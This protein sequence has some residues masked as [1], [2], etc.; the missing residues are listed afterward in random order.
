MLLLGKLRFSPSHL[1]L[2]IDR[3]TACVARDTGNILWKYTFQRLHCMQRGR[4]KT[5]NTTGE[6][7]Y[8]KWERLI[9][10][11]ICG[12]AFQGVKLERQF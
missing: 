5:E 10:L 3:A 6:K 11:P 2:A 12:S 4:I 9:T 1:D 7:S 8:S